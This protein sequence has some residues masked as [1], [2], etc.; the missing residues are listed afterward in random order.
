M[1]SS[2]GPTLVT[3][4][5]GFLGAHIVRAL[6]RRGERPRCL[7]RATSDRRN[8][9]SLPVEIVPGD[10]TDTASLQRATKGV[11]SVFH[12]AADYRLFVRDPRETYASNV[13]GTRNVLRSAAEAGVKR[14]VYTSSVGTLGLNRNG[15]PA[16]EETPVAPADMV[17][18]YKRSKFLAEQVAQEWA[19]QGLPVVIVNPS[20]PVGELDAKPTPTGQILVRFLN[21][22]MPVYVETGLNLVDVRDVAEGH[23]LAAEKGRVG[24]RYI[25][26]HRNMTLKEILDTLARLTG[27]PAPRLRVPHWIPLAVAAVDTSIARLVGRSPEI[28][29]EGVRLSRHRMFFDASKAVRELG[30]PQTPIEE[31]LERA[32]R[33]FR[34]NGYVRSH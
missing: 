20:T 12:C 14:V 33:W 7:V 19:V 18:H 32:V 34:E 28:P 30:L 5:T 15:R 29:I 26:G 10:L 13:E 16:T 6:L 24:E 4:G 2:S 11:A 25:L 9:A 3:G 21:R 8:L 1:G 31:A 17:G 22:R 23:L 27:L